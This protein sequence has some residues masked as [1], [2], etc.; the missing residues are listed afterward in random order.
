MS[1]AKK[2]R[3]F[4]VINLVAILA[5]GVLIGVIIMQIWR[6]KTQEPAVLAPFRAETAT[7]PISSEFPVQITGDETKISETTLSEI[8]LS[9][10]AKVIASGFKCPCGCGH[11]AYECNCLKSPG[12]RDIKH[13][14]QSLVDQGK[15][16]EEIKKAVISRF[17][18][19]VIAY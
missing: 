2:G 8:Q 19:N 11:F 5:A 17:G 4:Q 16:S 18:E 12:S 9:H 1:D 13:L 3:M 6:A 7:A 14:I 10:R 15:D